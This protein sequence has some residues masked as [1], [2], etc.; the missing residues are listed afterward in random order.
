MA[1]EL[2]AVVTTML[3]NFERMDFEAVTKATT[4]DVQGI[5]ELSR[6]WMRTRKEMADYFKQVASSVTKI[7]DSKM[8]DIHETVLGDIGLVTCWLEQDYVLEGKRQHISAPTTVVL[9]RESGPWKIAVF[10]SLPLPPAT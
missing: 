4:N 1:G 7:H 6:K 10:H 2:T 9:R 5:D 3:S 8:K